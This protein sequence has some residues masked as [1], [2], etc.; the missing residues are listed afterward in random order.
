MWQTTGDYKKLRWKKTK[1]K[2]FIYLCVCVCLFVDLDRQAL[3]TARAMLSSGYWERRRQILNSCLVERD[4]ARDCA[5]RD[6]HHAPIHHSGYTQTHTRVNKVVRQT[7]HLYSLWGLLSCE[8]RVWG[9]VDAR[10]PL[11]EHWDSSKRYQ[12]A[13]IRMKWK[14]AKKLIHFLFS[15]VD[16]VNGFLCLLDNA[17]CV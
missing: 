15:F 14:N 6:T 9:S 7:K 12:E 3:L 8:G 5:W 10:L 16:T 13:S 2:E 1:N 11:L 4:E 17:R